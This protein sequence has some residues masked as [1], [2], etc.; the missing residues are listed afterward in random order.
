MKTTNLSILTFII[1]LIVSSCETRPKTSSVISLKPNASAPVTVKKIQV[2]DSRVVRGFRGSP[3]DGTLKT[4]EFRGF[5]SEYPDTLSEGFDASSG[6]DY[7]YNDNDGLRITL[8]DSGGFD[9]IVLRG[10][11]KTRLYADTSSLI[12]P[13]DKKPLCK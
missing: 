12:E 2:T 4:Y 6:V 9:T 11:A 5:F 3:V 10:G 8:K 7:S 13:N 1:L